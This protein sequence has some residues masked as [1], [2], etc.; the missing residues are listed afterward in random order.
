MHSICIGFKC[1]EFLCLQR[2]QHFCTS[3]RYSDNWWFVY[4]QVP[5]E[6]I[7]H[8]PKWI[9]P[10]STFQFSIALA[11]NRF[12]ELF[13]DHYFQQWLWLFLSTIQ[14]LEDKQ[15]NFCTCLLTSKFEKL[16][17]SQ[18]SLVSF[19]QR[20]ACALQND[21]I[22]FIFMMYFSQSLT[23]NWRRS[24]SL[25]LPLLLSLATSIYDHRLYA[26]HGISHQLRCFW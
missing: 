8:Y 20:R 23:K 6:G 14:G 17:D 26:C 22:S 11:R 9:F 24:D 18:W 13:S 1:P 16:S 4:I 25:N 7:L 2:H 3:K 19:E 12:A 10:R 5:S 21:A 15:N